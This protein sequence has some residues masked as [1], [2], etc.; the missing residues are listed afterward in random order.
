M[1]MEQQCFNIYEDSHGDRRESQT[2]RTEDIYQCLQYPPPAPRTQP[3]ETEPSTSD[4]CGGKKMILPLL[5][6]IIFLLTA[7]LFI[8]TM[9]YYHFIQTRVGNSKNT[10]KELWILHANMFYLFWSNHGDCDTAESFCAKRNASLAA[11]AEYN[12]AWLQSQAKGKRL[13]VRTETT[14]GSGDSA[15]VHTHTD[16][17]DFDCD[18]LDGTSDKNQVEG[19]V[20]EKE[21]K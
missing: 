15:F 11:A 3:N 21:A 17:D 8:A 20:C 18:F 1:E 14:N 2:D 9:H 10:N 19:W 13:L 16:E 7:I 12:L 4:K 5:I 6:I